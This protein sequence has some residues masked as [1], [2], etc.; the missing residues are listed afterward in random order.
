MT[1]DKELFNELEEKDLKMHIEMGDD[2]KYNV[3]GVGTITFQREHVAPLTLKN[4]MHVPRLMK[5]LVS[6]SMLEDRGYDVIFSK[7]KAFLRHIATGQVKKIGIQVNNLYKLEAE[8]CV[9][10]STKA[11]RVQIRDASELWH[12]R[13]GHLHHGALKIMQQ[14]SA[15]LPKGTLEQ[16]DTCKGCTLGKYTRSCFNNRDS[17]SDA[18]I[19]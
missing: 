8:E 17:R 4:V 6:I 12:R 14:I 15:G 16:V 3:T 5:N 13:L 11:E 19:E 1:S 18:I 7:G 9:A 2:G 10:L